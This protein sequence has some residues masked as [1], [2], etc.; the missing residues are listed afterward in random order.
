[1]PPVRRPQRES[2]LDGENRQGAGGPFLLPALLSVSLRPFW[3]RD[4]M[5]PEP[6][7]KA[8]SD[9][10][11]QGRTSVLSA[12]RAPP[13][14]DPPEGP[15]LFIP[16]AESSPL[17]ARRTPETLG[18]TEGPDEA[19]SSDLSRSS[20]RGS[21]FV[22]GVVTKPPVPPPA[23]PPPAAHQLPQQTRQR[24]WS[25]DGARAPAAFPPAARLGGRVLPTPTDVEGSV[26][27]EGSF[28]V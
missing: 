7:P 28:V 19:A 15:S 25:D 16:R 3:D 14:A 23:S 17:P 18:C 1:M 2:G 12:P 4:K 13:R 10:G 11:A 24:R 20:R 26:T 9:G 5:S 27:P 21:P 8:N 6:L 22:R